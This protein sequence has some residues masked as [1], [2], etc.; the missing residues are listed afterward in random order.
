MQL[1]IQDFLGRSEREPIYYFVK[2]SQKLHGNEKNGPKGGVESALGTYI[3]G[4]Y[5]SLVDLEPVTFLVNS[6]SRI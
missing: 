1:W 3:N 2:Y 6:V 4:F 5:T